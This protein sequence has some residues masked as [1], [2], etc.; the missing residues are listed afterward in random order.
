MS[1]RSGII[2]L[3]FQFFE[4]LKM[5]LVLFFH[6]RNTENKSRLI[7]YYSE[8]VIFEDWKENQF[9]KANHDLES[10]INLANLYWQGLDLK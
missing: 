6:F 5:D 4:P 10:A 9:S 3:M 1:H 2:P 7:E 8:M